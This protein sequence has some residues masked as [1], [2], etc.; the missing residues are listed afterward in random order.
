[1]Q[2]GG[3]GL[4]AAET[5]ADV[6]VAEQG[7]GNGDKTVA[8]EVD[9][10][11]ETPDVSEGHDETFNGAELE[12][13]LNGDVDQADERAAQDD[14]LVASVGPDGILQ[15]TLGVP[16]A[17]IDVFSEEGKDSPGKKRHGKPRVQPD[18]RWDWEDAETYQVRTKISQ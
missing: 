8:H 17:G 13:I 16:V 12:A 9:G 5:T 15:A 4:D 6:G 3:V 1:M 14:E 10:E 7:A 11:D 18:I 2:A